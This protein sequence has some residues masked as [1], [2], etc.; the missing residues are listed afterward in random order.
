[1][2]LAEKAS[3][4]ARLALAVVAE[5]VRNQRQAVVEVAVLPIPVAKVA[6][7]ARVVRSVQWAPVHRHRS[8]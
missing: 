5:V 1:M 8:T 7:E 4:S 3:E 2:Q 6:V